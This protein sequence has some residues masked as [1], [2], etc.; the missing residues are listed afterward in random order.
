MYKTTASRI[1]IVFFPK[2][3][4]II[5]W[6]SYFEN[7]IAFRNCVEEVNYYQYLENLVHEIDFN[8][9]K[10]HDHFFSYAFFP[11]KTLPIVK[12]D[13][14]NTSGST[15]PT[16]PIVHPSSAYG[17]LS[18]N[19]S[20][21]N[22]VLS[23]IISS[24]VYIVLLQINHWIVAQYYLVRCLKTWQWAHRVVVILRDTNTS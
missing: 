17:S 1:C 9:I 5:K 13:P 22:Q 10:V 12:V 7:L 18:R 21:D 4:W 20:T 15:K 23:K 3:V 11:A 19:S 24:A 6:N 8:Y 14:E 2:T 16:S